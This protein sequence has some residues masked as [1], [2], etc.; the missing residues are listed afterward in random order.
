MGF[1]PCFNGYYT[2]TSSIVSLHIRVIICFNPCF[3]GYYTS[4]GMAC[5]SYAT[6]Y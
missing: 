5:D 1:N 4:T 3:N 2:S 6:G